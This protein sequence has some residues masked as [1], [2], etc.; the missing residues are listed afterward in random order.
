MATWD[1]TEMNHHVLICNGSSC[2][3]KGGEEV[4]Q[5]IRKEIKERD[6]DVRVHTTRT[7]CNGRCKDACVVIVYP[8]GTWYHEVDEQLA[9]KIVAS[10]LQ[11]GEPVENAVTYTSHD[12][13]MTLKNDRVTGVA[14]EKEKQKI[15]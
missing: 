11:Q 3:R 2:M 5:A 13:G 8:E 10:H 9:E 4:T 7:R 6:L 14:K 12:N 1:L 15:K